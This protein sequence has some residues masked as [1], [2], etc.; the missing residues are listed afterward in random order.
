MSLL[1]AANKLVKAA[2]PRIDPVAAFA[3]EYPL[4]VWKHFGITPY[5]HQ[6][7]AF[8][9]PH[10]FVV[11]VW[12]RRAGKSTKKLLK[13]LD[14]AYFCPFPR[15]RF[16]FVA[17]TYEQVKDII[18]DE[19]KSLL[20]KVPGSSIHEGALMARIPTAIGSTARIRLYGVD[21]PRQRLRGS[22][23]DG[24]VLDEFQHVPPTVF[25]QQVRPML[26]DASRR[27]VDVFGRKNQWADFIGTALGKNHLY[28]YWRRA[29]QWM[30]G[31]GVLIGRGPTARRT[32]SEDWAASLLRYTDTNILPPEEIE[33]IRAE[34][35][36][37]EFAQ[38][39]DCDFEAAVEGA[40]LREQLKD[41]KARGGVGD[42]PYEPSL[43]PVHTAWD[44]GWDDLMVVWFFQSY[45]GRHRF[46]HVI[47]LGNTSIPQM[48]NLVRETRYPLGRNYVPHDIAV[49]DL[50][51]GKTR[52]TILQEN[53]LRPV[54]VKKV[55]VPDKLAAARRFMPKCE[56]DS[57]CTTGLDF[58]ALW[59]REKDP[60]TGLVRP[61]PVHDESA[62]YGDA[63]ATA[64][65]GV[66][67]WTIDRPRATVAEL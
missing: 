20:E 54:T 14:R 44:L 55:S 35:T 50:A 39:Y 16:A 48:V 5:P 6:R 65:L 29:C 59:R 36:E 10:R 49:T 11:D 43:G 26:S 56:F 17:P 61:D 58:L 28:E 46:I 8:L 38:E 21:S 32:F 67:N 22:Y 53:G 3:P 19:L 18:W 42:F 30:T 41:L 64:A 51:I 27:G 15:G 33:A 52:R 40:V 1:A 66:P 2:P 24:I 13:I 7:D 4:Q 47:A 23:L 62:H 12:H 25:T 45:R 57:A 63:F 37:A 31:E 60:K 34:I 9:R